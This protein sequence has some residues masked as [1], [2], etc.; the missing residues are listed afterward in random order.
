MLKA[1]FCRSLPPPP[2]KQGEVWAWSH[3]VLRFRH[4][5]QFFSPPQFPSLGQ[6]REDDIL[7]RLCS[8]CFSYSVTKNILTGWFYL[9]A[10]KI[11]HSSLLWKKSNDRAP[12][13]CCDCTDKQ[14]IKITK[15]SSYIRTFRWDQV[16]SQMCASQYMGKC[17]NFS[18]CMRRP[19]VIYDFA[20]DPSNLPIYMRKI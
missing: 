16:Q 9:F 2:V 13:P 19:L 14:E 17:E 18:T 3:E 20:P 8:V 12:S 15:F 10:W 7:Y 4:G 6:S 1:G 11:C 5:N